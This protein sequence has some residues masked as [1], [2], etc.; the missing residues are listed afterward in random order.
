MMVNFKILDWKIA[1]AIKNVGHDYDVDRVELFPTSSAARSAS[2]VPTPRTW[3]SSPRAIRATIIM[4]LD[5][6]V[7]R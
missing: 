2:G 7:L 6:A 4:V 5:K 3:G 1:I